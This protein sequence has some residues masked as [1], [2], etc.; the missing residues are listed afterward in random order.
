MNLY[1]LS[2]DDNRDYDTYSDCVVAAESEEAARVINPGGSDQWDDPRT[3][4]WAR[5]PE[6]VKVKLIGVAIEGTKAGVICAS[7]HAG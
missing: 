4:N 6:F 7:Y 1:Y 5:K 2:Q 3:S